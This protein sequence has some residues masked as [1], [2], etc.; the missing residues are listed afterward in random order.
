MKELTCSILLIILSPCLQIINFLR[1]PAWKGKGMFK[2]LSISEKKNCSLFPG[3][4]RA[5]W[6]GLHNSFEWHVHW[7]RRVQGCQGCKGQL[8]EP[9]T[10]TLLCSVLTKWSIS[11]G[12]ASVGGGKGT[13][14]RTLLR[15]LKEGMCRKALD[16]C[17]P[18]EK[19]WVNAAVFV[20]R[21]ILWATT[22]GDSE[23]PFS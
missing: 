16:S 6:L 14:L 3:Y 1:G 12:I 21:S 7:I 10:L 15:R 19:C 20:I 22:S 13:Y 11:A 9:F 17:L 2:D 5:S 18:C 4:V 8:A 23:F